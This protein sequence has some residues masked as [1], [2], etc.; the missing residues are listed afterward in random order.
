M[1]KSGIL[2]AELSRLVA[3]MGHGDLLV[4]GDAGMPVPGGVPTID[5]ALRHGVPGFLDT[6]ATV[7]SELRVEEGVVAGEMAEA[8]PEL[9]AEFAAAW[10]SDVQLR[11]VSHDELKRLTRSARA[12]VRTGECTAYANVVLVSGVVFGGR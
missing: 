7:L 11:R 5:L 8:S 9:S 10:P 4:I 2:H 3:S 1:K 12:L 6:L